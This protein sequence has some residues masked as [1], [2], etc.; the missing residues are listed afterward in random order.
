MIRC[1]IANPALQSVCIASDVCLDGIRPVA[2]HS[3][4][5]HVRLDR[6][7][8]VC[9]ACIESNS[10]KQV[11]ACLSAWLPCKSDSIPS[12]VSRVSAFPA[13]GGWTKSNG[14]GW[15]VPQICKASDAWL[16]GWIASVGR[17]HCMSWEG[18]KARSS[19]QWG[20]EGFV[21]PPRSGFNP[22]SV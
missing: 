17:V 13:L 14:Y 10:R 11:P 7:P 15:L 21:P 2:E 22:M 20:R 1:C 6:M 18:R 16:V 19:I 12:A 9:S 3:I 4:P 8:C 5:S